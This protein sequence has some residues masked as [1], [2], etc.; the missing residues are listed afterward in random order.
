M[1]YK[2]VLDENVFKHAL[3]RVDKYNKPDDSAM[4]LLRDISNNCH[5]IILDKKLNRVFINVLEKLKSTK[6]ERN[7]RFL[8]ALMKIKINGQK[9]L[10]QDYVAKDLE[11]F[12]G[13]ENM[14]DDDAFMAKLAIE[15]GAHYIVTSDENFETAIK[16][17]DFL[18]CQKIFSLDVKEGLKK[19]KEN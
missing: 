9:Y 2:F 8:F 5:R 12:Q 4:N 6:A 10:F 1:K 7:D 13:I 15:E 17:N 19:A 16:N 14:P 3:N 18:A 11:D